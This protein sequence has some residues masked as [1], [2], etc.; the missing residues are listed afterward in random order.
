MHFAR[1]D[2]ASEFLIKRYVA[3]RITIGITE[4]TQSLILTHNKL[5]PDWEPHDFQALQAAHFTLVAALDP[6]V[7]ILG[8]GAQ[9]HFPHPSITAELLT[10]GIGFEAM[11]T[12]AA[13]RTYNVLLS[14]GRRVV[15]ALLL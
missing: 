15:A 14:E 6:E 1:D 12:A 8:T 3:G 7:V 9:L 13:C 5:I 2:N 11:D 10:Q 4:H